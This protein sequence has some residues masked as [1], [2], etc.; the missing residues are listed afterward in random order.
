M[1]EATVPGALGASGKDID[2]VAKTSIGL[3]IGTSAV[4]VGELRLGDRPTLTRLGQVQLP[5]GSVIEGEVVEPGDVAAALRT[6]WKDTKIKGK[7]VRVGVPLSRAIVRTIEVADLPD[8][9]LRSMIGLELADHVPLDPAHTVFD[10][11]PLDRI[12]TDDGP[13]R[14]VLLAAAPHD[15]IQPTLAAVQQAGLTVAAVDV[16]PLA[17]ARVFPPAPV[18]NAAG[19]SVASVDLVISVGA[20]TMLALVCTAGHLLFNRKATSPVGAQ[21]TDRIQY[22]LAIGADVAEMTKRR[23]ITN[24]NRHLLTR[25]NDLADTVLDELV[26]DIHESILYYQ[27]QPGARPIDR[28][29]LSGGGSLLAGLDHHLAERLSYPVVFGDPFEGLT[30]GVEGLTRDVQDEY[31]PYVATAIAY[32]LGGLS[33]YPK[34]DL[35]PV[36]Q[37]QSISRS[38][39][40]LAGTGVVLLGA[41]GLMYT[42]ARGEVG[43]VRDEVVAVRGDNAAAIA[44]LEALRSEA[45]GQITLSKGA[46]R[47]MV[48]AADSRRI[49]WTIA[50]ADLDILSLGVGVELDGFVG[51]STV[52]VGAAA[53]VASATVGTVTFSGEAAAID[54]IATWITTIEADDRFTD[55]AT[56]SVRQLVKADGAVVYRFDAS[57][58]LTPNALFS[59]PDLTSADRVPP[60][61][62]VPTTEVAG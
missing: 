8:G 48:A 17:L 27:A 38:H 7:S 59:P 19:A 29:V 51:T 45:P 21:L 54:V 62:D 28:V 39:L 25:V 33:R 14:R 61:S 34:L 36:L 24:E 31:E 15:A 52:S 44:E 13:R 12:S 47:Q 58:Q 16:A 43:T 56:P 23:V 41:L 4:R 49:D 32:A 3:D 10:I 37:R 30:I 46:L 42:S 20:G 35:K 9:E 55:I 5:S 53:A 6:L 57:V 26:R 40:V 60:S 2:H 18:L 50:F 1:T 22:Q 11:L